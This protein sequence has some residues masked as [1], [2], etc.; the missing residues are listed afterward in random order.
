MASLTGQP[1][2]AP[3]WRPLPR[4]SPPPGAIVSLII[5]VGVAWRPGSG[6][7]HDGPALRRRRRP[8]GGGQLGIGV[9]R[10]QAHLSPASWSSTSG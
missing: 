6:D 7:E 5:H 4:C 1:S 3:P 2:L 10:T 8:I 9:L